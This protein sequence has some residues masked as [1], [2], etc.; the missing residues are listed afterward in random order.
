MA[1]ETRRLGRSSAEVT[2]MGLGTATLAGNMDAVAESEAKMIVIDAFDTGIRYFDTGALLR[3]RQVRALRRRRIAQSHRLDPLDQ[4]RPAPQAAAHTPGAERPWQRPLDFEP[5]FDFS[6]DGVMRAYEDSLQRLGLNHVDILYMHDVDVFTAR[7]RR[8]TR[9]SHRMDRP[10]RR[11][12][13]SAGAAR[14]RRSGSVSTRPSRSPTPS[15]TASGTASCSPGA[16]RSSSRRRY[17]RSFPPSPSTAPPSSSAV[18]SI[19][20]CSSAA[21]PGTTRKAPPEVV[22]RVKALARVCDAHHVPL[23]AAALQF[24]ARPSRGR[25]RDPGSALDRRAEPDLR[26]VE[27]RN[28]RVAVE[29][30]QER[31]ADRGGRPGTVL[32]HVPNR[33]DRRSGM[34]MR[35][36][37]ARIDVGARREVVDRGRSE[38]AGAGRA[39]LQRCTPS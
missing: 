14:S 1:F 31:E 17:R 26:M 39:E 3:L 34:L 30:P 5:Y 33:R 16:T 20:A 21:R 25:E 12:T 13:S 29:R 36:P 10:T 11:S 8:N 18:P 7:A 19:P 4:G 6:Y 24:P 38:Y 15:S 35:E 2:V 22:T 28:P 27:P 32:A 37:A 9:E 23:A